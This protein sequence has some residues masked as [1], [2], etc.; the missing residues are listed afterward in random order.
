MSGGN[1]ASGGSGTSGS[2]GMSINA[3]VTITGSGYTS[4]N[5]TVSGSVNG[6]AYYSANT[7][8]FNN[9][10][11]VATHYSGIFGG[12]LNHFNNTCSYYSNVM[13]GYSLNADYI[14]AF[15]NM[16]GGWN[17]S[18]SGRYSVLAGGC[19]ND[20]GCGCS[21]VYFRDIFGGALNRNHA[22]CSQI[23][24]KYNSDSY[25]GLYTYVGNMSKASGSFVIQHPNPACCETMQLVHSF[26]ESPN[27][28][29]NLYRYEVTTENCSAI[30]ELPDYFKY[31]NTDIT[32]RVGAKNHFGKAYGIIDETKS[33]VIFTSNCDGAYNILIMGTRCD[34]DAVQY[35]EGVERNKAQ[36]S[37]FTNA[38]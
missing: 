22:N 27:A 8:G 24:A 37:T 5:S 21:G 10:I 12:A 15:A 34:R 32:M 14:V 26:V 19:S 28:G 4:I 23:I 25:S 30:L 16:Q 33:C 35:W 31:L 6:G 2:S 18:G 3:P 38:N 9:S 11:G 17:N 1:G 13:S 20:G 29:D 36:H 7:N